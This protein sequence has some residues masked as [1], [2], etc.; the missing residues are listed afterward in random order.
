MKKKATTEPELVRRERRRKRRKRV[1][2]A[3]A[4]VLYCFSTTALAAEDP[5][6]VVNNLSDFIF[7][8][9]RALSLIHI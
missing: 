7:G 6:A 9:V 4:V 5:I 1:F 2:T 3:L 8:L